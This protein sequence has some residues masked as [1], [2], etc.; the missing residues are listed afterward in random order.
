MK[1]MP[2][3]VAGGLSKRRRDSKKCILALAVALPSAVLALS[4]ASVI[5]SAQTESILYAFASA[6]DVSRSESALVADAAGNFYGAAVTGGTSGMGGVFKLTR[7]GSPGGAWSESVIY[8]FQGK[9]DGAFPSGGLAIDKAGNLYGTAAMGDP[10]CSCGTVYK[11]KPPTNAGGAWSFRTMHN[12][13]GET[14]GFAPQT[15]VVLDSKGAVYGATTAGGALGYGVAYKVASVG[16]GFTQTIL[17][18]FDG[19]VGGFSGPL[20]FH[21]AGNLYG[22]SGSGGASRNGSVFQLSPPANVSGEWTETILGTFAPGTSSGYFPRGTL[23]L[24]AKGQLY[25]TNTYGGTLKGGATGFGTVFRLSPPT[26]A[27]GGWSLNIL[28]TF[29]GGT[30][31]AGPFAG[32]VLDQSNGVFSG[33]T[34][35]GGLSPG[36]GV[37]F[38]LTPPLVSGGAWTQSVLHSFVNAPDGCYVYSDLTFDSSG[39]LFGTTGYGGG[40]SEGG[41][42]FQVTP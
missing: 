18:T 40:Q 39:N 38:S 32:L 12:F 34:S 6:P 23:I 20:I 29:T 14:D 33:T 42:V 4:L 11:L 13:T 30:D 35:A 5:A 27:G 2:R 41:I 15:G 26:V 1:V 24:D 10:I 22:V 17:K 8:S 36:C 28:Y 9:T 19:L 31:G 37:V 7:P 3:L 25:G 16:S 21:S